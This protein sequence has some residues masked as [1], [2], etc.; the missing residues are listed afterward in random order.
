[1]LADD[2]LRRTGDRRPDADALVCGA[3]RL[4]AGMLDA[5]V[6]RFASGLRH[7]GVRRGDRVAVH[8]E[9]SSDAVVSIF[10]A[11]R[12]G[13]IA[14]P[15]NPTMKAAK[16]AYVLNDCTPAALVSDRRTSAVI[17]EAVSTLSS[18][19]RI[20]FAG[21]PAGESVDL[22]HATTVEALLGS[23]PDIDD[24]SCI[25]LDLAALIYTSGSTGGPKGVMLT[26]ANIV[27]ATTSINAYLGNTSDDVILDVLPLS[28]D[29]GLYQLFLA[30]QSGGRQVLERSFAYPATVL[31]LMAKE[32]VTG[33]PLVPMMAALLLRNDLAGVD[34][35]ALR[36]VTNTGAVLPPAH[37]AALRARLPHVRIF[38][39]YGL[40]ECKRVSFL[41][42]AELDARPTSVGKPMDNVEVYLV[43]DEGV[44]HDRGVG[45]LVIRGSNV[46][47]G[48]WG[49]PEETVRV[50][51][52]GPLPGQRVLHTGD[53]FRIDEEGFLYFQHRL[54]DVIKSRGQKVSPREVEDVL[55]GAPGVTEAL[56]IGVP[57]PVVGEALIGYVTLDP[58]AMVTPRELRMHCARHL[59]D[60]MLPRDIEIVR[61]LPHNGSGKL[62]RR[63]LRQSVAV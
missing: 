21:A 33:L 5:A 23:A 16:L 59:E 28:F 48:Y 7:A 26:H 3:T 14:V 49:A 63:I 31:E 25:D 18:A 53:V 19:P 44:R 24:R 47:Q 61:E 40:T 34:L 1:L 22:P 56:V 10:G 11:L 37:I 12:A 8:L 32:D 41:D 52:P 42:P 29:Y 2:L 60:F 20:V 57:D 27:A 4:T 43:D 6:T 30:C 39:M 62:S 13:A 9:N 17:A 58:D 50:L 35:P 51:E 45:E 36:Y 46:M 15:L 54:D 38:S 55:H